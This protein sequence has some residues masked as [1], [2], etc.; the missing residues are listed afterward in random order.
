M[1][2]ASIGLT[3]LIPQGHAHW[4]READTGSHESSGFA[5]SVVPRN[6]LASGELFNVGYIFAEPN[7]ENSRSRWSAYRKNFLAEQLCVKRILG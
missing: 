7:A 3:A 5:S 2:R 4:I 6:R 1:L